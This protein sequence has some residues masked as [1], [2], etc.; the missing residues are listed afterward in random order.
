MDHYRNHTNE[1]RE[2]AAY[3]RGDFILADLY[4]TIRDLEGRIQE[5][6]EEL[7]QSDADRIADLQGD[8]D[9]LEIVLSTALSNLPVSVP[10]D[11]ETA[12]NVQEFLKQLLKSS[13][14]LTKPNVKRH[15]VNQ[16]QDQSSG[17]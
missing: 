10:N 9:Q 15:K 13:K 8:V 3:V 2:R 14:P 7:E 4:D 5:L 1:E 16:C 6:E 17:I 12:V 11:Y